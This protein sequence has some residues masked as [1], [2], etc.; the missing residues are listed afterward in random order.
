MRFAAAGTHHKS[1]A[2]ITMCCRI[3]TFLGRGG[4][5][6]PGDAGQRITSAKQ[7]APD[8]AQAALA[9]QVEI[10]GIGTL[11]NPIVRR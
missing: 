6:S 5:L 4:S 10:E 8:P 11:S 2:A 7:N 1:A 3:V 9:H